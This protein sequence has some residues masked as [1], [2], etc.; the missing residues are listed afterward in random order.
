V[1]GRIGGLG[2]KRQQIG[3]CRPALFGELRG[4]VLQRFLRCRVD[5]KL[6][7]HAVGG[8]CAGFGR[9]GKD[10]DVVFQR[11]APSGSPLLVASDARGRVEDGSQTVASGGQRI[12]V[13]PLVEKEIASGLRRQG[14]SFRSPVVPQ[15]PPG[16]PVSEGHDNSQQHDPTQRATQSFHDVVSPTMVS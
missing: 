4:D 11:P 12:A 7:D 15:Q 3:K 10:G 5:R 8:S 6:M 16:C 14:V 1:G 9:S 13:R 2:Q